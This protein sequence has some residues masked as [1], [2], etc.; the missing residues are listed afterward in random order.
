MSRT[1]ERTEHALE[2][3]KMIRIQLVQPKIRVAV[4]AD[5]NGGWHATMY[6]EQGSTRDLQKRV[7]AAARE[8]NGLYVLSDER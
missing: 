3:G 8:M 4:F 2:L 7:D 5:A 1:C 6:A